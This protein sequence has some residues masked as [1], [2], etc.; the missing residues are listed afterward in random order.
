MARHVER[1]VKGHRYA[2]I[3][4]DRRV[5]DAVEIAEGDAALRLVVDEEAQR[6]RGVQVEENADGRALLD[7][8]L[9]ALCVT[10]AVHE[11]R[12]LPVY[13]HAPAFVVLTC[14]QNNS[15]GCTRDYSA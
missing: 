13:V 3:Q 2:A 12:P 15:Q 11:P 4:A 1:G 8:T 14:G 5:K 10:A 7:A 9:R 6:V